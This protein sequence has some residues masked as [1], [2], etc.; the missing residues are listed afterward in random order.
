MSISKKE[1][2]SRK[3]L[4]DKK[5]LPPINAVGAGGILLRVNIYSK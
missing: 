4:S 1:F 3:L 5:S 2:M